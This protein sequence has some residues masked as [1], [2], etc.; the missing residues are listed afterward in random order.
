LGGWFVLHKCHDTASVETISQGAQ[1][2]LDVGLVHQH[3]PAD[4]R[5]E[6]AVGRGGD[7]SYL[8]VGVRQADSPNTAVRGL[9]AAGVTVDT[10]NL[11]GRGHQLGRN[12]GDIATA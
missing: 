5:V 1:H 10:E 8:K 9:D 3:Q 12:D 6:R 7:I 4:D 11:S 2:R